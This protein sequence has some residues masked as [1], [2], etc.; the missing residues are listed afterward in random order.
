MIFFASQRV[1][2]PFWKVILKP[3]GFSDILFVFK[4]PKA[5]SLE[6][7]VQISLRSNRVRR[8]AN[9]TAQVSLRTLGQWRR[10]FFCLTSFLYIELMD[11]DGHHIGAVLADPAAFCLDRIVEIDAAP[12]EVDPFQAQF[13]RCNGALGGFGIDG[14]V[15]D[16]LKLHT[17]LTVEDDTVNGI[18]VIGISHAVE[19]DIANGDLPFHGFSA[20]FGRNDTGEP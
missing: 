14:T 13:G 12:G 3:Y 1:I 19:D 5:I 10:A 2:F 8:K 9:T 17:I 11:T 15:E 18:G 4:L 16:R 6:R 20:T 7:F